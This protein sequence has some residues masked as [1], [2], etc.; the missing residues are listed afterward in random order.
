[1]AYGVDNYS[2]PPDIE[3][4]DAQEPE[5]LEGK[6]HKGHAFEADDGRIFLV[7]CPS[8]GR[9]NYTPAVSSGQ[10]AWCGYEAQEEDLDE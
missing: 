3:Y 4:P 1:M 9:E 6:P 8:C 5:E 10:C 2:E 7:R